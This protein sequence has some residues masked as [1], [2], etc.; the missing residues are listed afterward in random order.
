MSKKVT[1]S[2]TTIVKNEARVIGRCIDSIK[3]IVD[4]SVIV[5]TGSV[6][7]T[8]AIIKEKV[9][10]CY[11]TKWTGDYAEARN[12][13]VER[14]TS[15]WI[16]VQDA[17]EHMLPETVKIIKPILAKTPAHIWE[18]L[19]IVQ[20]YTD[21]SMI[22]TYRLYGHRLFR[23]GK[24]IKWAGKGHE[25]LTTPLN[26]RTQ[27]QRLII[28]HDKTPNAVSP[29]APGPTDLAQVFIDN[30]LKS[31]DKNPRDARSMFYLA[32]TFMG[33]GKYQKAIEWYHTY[34]NTSN[35]NDERYQARL[36][37]ARCYVLTNDHANAR[38]MMLDAYEERDDR[39]EGDLLLG[40]LAFQEGKYKQALIWFHLAEKKAEKALKGQWPD[41]LLFLEG[42][43][44]MYLPY[45][46]LAITYYKLGN[47]KKAKEYT[48]KALKILPNDKRLK[49]NLKFY[50]T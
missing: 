32:N 20:D 21:K 2:H 37:C 24:G 43:A 26:H 48:L 25:A 4:E 46:W 6:D 30:F 15:D 14:C 18:I 31:I 1:I 39:T 42:K 36:F 5:D 11:H 44:Y 33:R 38:K 8:V 47:K 17:D 41:T 10:K 16:L 49:G 7:K 22:P 50:E 23:N 28:M 45:D 34:L 19:V 3:K 13:G 12:Y 29:V 9:G 27:D 40:D 35:W